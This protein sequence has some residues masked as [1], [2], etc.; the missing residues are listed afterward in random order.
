MPSAKLPKNPV[1][2]HITDR[3]LMASMM[4][5][6]LDV[7]MRDLGI[8]YFNIERSAGTRSHE[9]VVKSEQDKAK[10]IDFFNAKLSKDRHAA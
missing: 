6:G 4:R 10:I 1:I 2:F 5:C 3:V 9:I 8:S 7:V